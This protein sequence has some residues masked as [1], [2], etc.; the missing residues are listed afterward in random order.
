MAI[1]SAN[2][3]KS[4]KS[5]RMCSQI[6]RKRMRLMALLTYWT[7]CKSCLCLSN[8]KIHLQSN[9]LNNK[10]YSSHNNRCHK[11]ELLITISNR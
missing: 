5:N 9:L 1:L 3:Y 4:Y 6:I 10:A 11:K 7:R 2:K 8:L